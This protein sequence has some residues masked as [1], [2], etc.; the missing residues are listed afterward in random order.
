LPPQFTFGTLLQLVDSTLRWDVPTTEY[1]V[2]DVLA[3][4]VVWLDYLACLREPTPMSHRGAS[5]GE[6]I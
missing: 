1:T 4:D 2:E 3:G 6:T 5:T